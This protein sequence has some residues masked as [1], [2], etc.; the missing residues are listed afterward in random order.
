[1]TMTPRARQRMWMV[2][3]VLI[4]VAATAGFALWGLSGKITY[5]YT[6]K[7]LATVSTKALSRGIRIGGLVKVGSLQKTGDVSAF[8]ITDNT[9]DTKI[10][11]KGVLPDLFREGQG[12][13]AYG[14]Y[15]PAAVT[16]TATQVL[17]KHD[18]K[19]MPPEVAKALKKTHDEATKN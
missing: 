8:T 7:D 5:F 18:E 16:F 4:G 13:V 12:I 17:A 14:T 1:M 9:A 3:I 19:Y 2:I 11:Y 10:V 15:D 6:P